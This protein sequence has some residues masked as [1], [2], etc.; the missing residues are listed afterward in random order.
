MQKHT[1]ATLIALVLII[2]ILVAWMDTRHAVE[3]ATKAHIE[4]IVQTRHDTIHIIDSVLKEQ[5]IYRDTG[6]IEYIH[7]DLD[8]LV[9]PDSLDSL[10][11]I[12]NKQ[13]RTSL[14][15][16]DSLNACI[17]MRKADSIAIDTLSKIKPDIIK[18]CTITEQAKS[19]G[20]GVLIGIAIKSLF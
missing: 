5:V 1:S 18:T 8:N 15:W 7:A 17:D 13:L 16:K 12:T 4:H 2:G 20:I 14:K 11:Q 19:M 9:P 3:P 6:R 10:L